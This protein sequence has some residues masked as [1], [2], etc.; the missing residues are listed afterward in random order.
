M[1][2]AVNPVRLDTT[3]GCPPNTAIYSDLTLAFPTAAVPNGIN[4]Q[5]VNADYQ[6]LPAIHFTTD[7]DQQ[8]TVSLGST[9]C[10]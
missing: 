7:Q 1:I 3:A 9:T 10:W 6:G 4:G 2:H 8:D 5:T